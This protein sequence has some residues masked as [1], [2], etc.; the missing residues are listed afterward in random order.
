MRRRFFVATALALLAACSKGTLPQSN[1]APFAR[2]APA[3]SEQPDAFRVLHA[4]R[5][6]PDASVPEGTLVEM[7]GKFYRTSSDGEAYG[8]GSVFVLDAF[9]QRTSRA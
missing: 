7:D 4:F 5:G 3:A 2:V 9:G 6:K 1:A 8:S